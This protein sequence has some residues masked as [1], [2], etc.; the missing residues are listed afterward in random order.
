ML[1]LLQSDMGKCFKCWIRFIKMGLPK[2]M[3]GGKFEIT[4]KIITSLVNC[5]PIPKGTKFCFTTNH[6]PALAVISNHRAGPIKVYL[7]WGGLYNVQILKYV[8][9]LHI[10][11]RVY[12]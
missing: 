2:D 6:S 12:T 4:E 3:N 8:S 9:S 10:L 11:G 1:N 5:G 7:G